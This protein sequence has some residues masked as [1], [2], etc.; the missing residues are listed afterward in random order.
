MNLGAPYRPHVKSLS[1]Q[2]E[3]RDLA[4][5]FGRG[6]PLAFDQCVERYAERVTALAARLLGWREGGEDVAQ[7]VFM[8]ALRRQRTFR[9][10]SSLWTWLTVITV[11]RC[12]SLQR[13]RWL[14]DKWMQAMTAMRGEAIATSGERCAIRDETATLIRQAVAELPTKYREVIVLRYLEELPLGEMAELLGERRNTIEVRLT[15]AKKLLEPKLAGLA[16]A[17]D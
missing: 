17:W 7:E 11:N 6:E 4:V 13:R 16:G 2:D 9:A 1:A 14:Y 8:A 3:D 12:R 15:R 10:E 5:R